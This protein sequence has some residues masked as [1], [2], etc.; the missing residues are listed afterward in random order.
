MYIYVTVLSSAR[1]P[2]IQRI[3]SRDA[4]R[5]RRKRLVSRLFFVEVTYTLSV[6]PYA[7]WGSSC[8]NCAI[9]KFAWG[10]LYQLERFPWFYCCQG[11]INAAHKSMRSVSWEI[12]QRTESGTS[13]PYGQCSVWYKCATQETDIIPIPPPPTPTSN[14]SGNFGLSSFF[15]LKF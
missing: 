12:P 4:V 14:I 10:E 2:R 8:S 11:S 3:F 6:S 5:I 7:R 9:R 1:R 15:I 13:G